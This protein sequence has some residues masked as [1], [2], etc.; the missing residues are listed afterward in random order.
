M[1]AV[2]R[3]WP[4]GRRPFV[5]RIDLVIMVTAGHTNLARSR[6]NPSLGAGEKEVRGVTSTRHC[7]PLYR[8]PGCSGCWLRPV[9]ADQYGHCHR[10]LYPGDVPARCWC[11]DDRA[12]RRGQLCRPAKLAAKHQQTHREPAAISKLGALSA[13]RCNVTKVRPSHEQ[14]KLNYE[15]VLASGV[16]MSFKYEN[17]AL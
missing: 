14:F 15:S 4:T 5:A 13:E 12:S 2:W 7:L 6:S 8:T 10:G 11:P 17:N 9:C 3:L 16:N 1:S